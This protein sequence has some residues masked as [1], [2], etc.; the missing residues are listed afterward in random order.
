MENFQYQKHTHFT[1]M[2]W[3]IDGGVLSGH[4]VLLNSNWSGK[5][6]INGQKIY[7]FFL[8]KGDFR[9]EFRNA[10]VVH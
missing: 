5:Q 8:M 6:N 7:I 4:E 9:N 10:K 3:K 1:S 2:N